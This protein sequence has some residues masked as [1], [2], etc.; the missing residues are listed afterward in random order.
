MLQNKSLN[1]NYYL[2]IVKFTAK[3]HLAETFI[4]LS[5]EINEK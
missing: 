4:H 5:V 2:V 1:V 3:F